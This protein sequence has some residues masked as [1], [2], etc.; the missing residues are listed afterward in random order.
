MKFAH[1]DVSTSPLVRAYEP[2]RI[3]VGEISYSR[4]LIVSQGR[5]LD[6]WRPQ[7]AD[8]LGSE[9][10]APVL[11]L[12]PEVIVLG[13]G[14]NQRFPDPTTYAAVMSRGVGLEIMDTGAACRTYN[15][16]MSENR[17]V[18]AALIMI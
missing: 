4:S 2:G 13:T 16:L 12:D 11:A 5:V 14:V 15:I 6:D 7:T 18:V 8:Q 9:D 10:F 17:R 3:Q 1:D